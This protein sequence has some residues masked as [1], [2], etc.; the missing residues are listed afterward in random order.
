MIPYTLLRGMLP[1]TAAL[2][3]G[4]VVGPDYGGAPIAAPR[5]EAGA[6]F[7][8]GVAVRN[9]VAV[10]PPVRWWTTLG[11]PVLSDLVEAALA[12]NT[13]VRIAS[14]RLLQSRAVLGQRTAAL[15]PSIS[16]NTF[17]LNNQLPVRDFVG[18]GLG[19]A[20][21]AV[22]K[23]LNIDLYNASFDAT[24]EI[25]IFGGKQR[26]IEQAAAQGEAAEA[27][28]A[29]AQVQVAAEVAQAY[30]TLRGAQ[31]R[32]ALTQQAATLQREA[33]GLSQQRLAGGAASSL[34]VERLRTQ[35][36]TTASQAP[37][38]QAQIDQSLNQIAVLVARE[39]GAVDAVLK[40]PRA[41]PMPPWVVAIGDPGDM[42]RR[43][44]DIRRAERQLAAA[45]AQIGQSV[46][47]LFPR[48]NLIGNAGWVSPNIGSIGSLA[49]STY[50]LGP[51]LSWS[52][53]DFGRTLAQIRQSE[54]GADEALAQ[55]EQTVLQAMQDA[56][57][58]LSRYGNQRTTVARLARASASAGKASMLTDQRNTAGTISTI[59]VLDVERQRL[60]AQQSLAQAQADYT[61]AY[62][63]LQKSLGLGW[64]LPVEHT[65]LIAR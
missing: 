52:I 1:V 53:L 6:P 19:S 36:E 2:L 43:R 54:A 34:D 35:F 5:A 8:R 16:A 47:R 4:C 31:K 63:A 60:Q 24:W 9:A 49:A 27:A 3:G 11:D 46:A 57:T 21:G 65:A 29:D 20:G 23:S 22:P 39:P 28:V 51:T 17:A 56:E 45:N 42:I 12:S 62:V 13:N 15:A 61:T 30:V 18:S 48:V 59:D 10:D 55:Y 7:M 32:L 37:Q 25:D 26:A 58:S 14:A 33:I 50:S 64:G 44:P 40:Q 38:F 41:V